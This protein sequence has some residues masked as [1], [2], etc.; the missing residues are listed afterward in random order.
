[1]VEAEGST[2]RFGGLFQ[3]LCARLFSL[4]TT[5]HFD[6]LVPFRHSKCRRRTA[7]R[8]WDWEKWTVEKRGTTK[9]RVGSRQKNRPFF[10][11]C[12]DWAPTGFY[13][14]IAFDQSHTSWYLHNLD[15]RHSTSDYAE[16]EEEVTI[17]IWTDFYCWTRISLTIHRARVMNESSD[18]A[19][20][21]NLPLCRTT[22]QT[23]NWNLNFRQDSAISWDTTADT[24]SNPAESSPGGY[25]YSFLPQSCREAKRSATQFDLRCFMSRAHRVLST[26]PLT[27]A[28]STSSESGATIFDSQIRT[29][30]TTTNPHSNGMVYTTANHI[31]VTHALFSSSRLFESTAIST[32]IKPTGA[33]SSIVTVKRMNGLYCFSI[34]CSN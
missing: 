17:L 28:R 27:A 14:S 24:V 16:R 6:G 19:H 13:D 20:S 29:N 3:V 34:F 8:K 9:R 4:V 2:Y 18:S 15:G 22:S 26:S 33:V 11:A 10:R 25:V 12:P 21:L 5:S 32:G 23:I 1:M 30:I 31:R 7:F